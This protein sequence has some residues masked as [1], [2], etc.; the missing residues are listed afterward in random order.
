MQSSPGSVISWLCHLLV[1]SSPGSVISWL[2]H[3][4]VMSSPG[5]VISW[6]GHLLVLS[7]PP[8]HAVI[9][10]LCLLPQDMQSSPGSVI[11]WFCHLLVQSS[12]GSVCSPKTMQSSPGSVCSPKTMQSSPGSVCSL[13]TCSHLPVLSA[14]PEF[15]PQLHPSWPCLVSLAALRVGQCCLGFGFGFA[16]RFLAMSGT[17]EHCVLGSVVGCVQRFGVL[18]LAMSGTS[19]TETE[20]VFSYNARYNGMTHVPIKQVGNVFYQS[21]SVTF[22]TI[23]IVGY[24]TL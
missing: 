12:P 18:F 6:F 1:L 22:T 17:S 8:R 2:C 10:W 24:R 20:T 4:L 21:I 19:E 3:L 11:S 15:L 16:V 23:V 7:A 5:S 13:K 14:P 9:S